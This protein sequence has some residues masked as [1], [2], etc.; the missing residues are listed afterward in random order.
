[1]EAMAGYDRAIVIDAMVSGGRPGTIYVLGPEDL[2]RTRNAHSTHDG[3]P[4]AALELGRLAGLRLPAEIRIFAI[5]AEDVERF[6][7]SLT[8]AVERAV[9]QVADEVMRHL[10]SSR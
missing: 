3:E 1:M 5:E 8:P 7:E 4:G 9:P 10:R 2:A 6:G